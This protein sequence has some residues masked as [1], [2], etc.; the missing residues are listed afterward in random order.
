MGW[1]FGDSEPKTDTS[2][3]S[4]DSFSSSTSDFS[5]SSSFDTGSSSFGDSSFGSSA[6]SG[7]G[8]DSG[9]GSG[10][11]SGDAEL[12]SFLMLEQQK[13]QMQTMIHKMNDICWETCVG[14]P[15]SKL[16]SRTETCISNCVERF[17]DTSLFI[18]NRFA[19]MLSKSGGMM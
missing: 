6:S 19:Q 9:P 16:D 13:A 7:L 4:F 11:S 18:T 10:S 12:Q 17:I 5:S 14:S 8:L 15:G 2:S 1:F 3:S